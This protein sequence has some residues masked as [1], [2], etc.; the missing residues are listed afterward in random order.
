MP[1]YCAACGCEVWLHHEI[2]Y[3]WIQCLKHFHAHACI[4]GL[5]DIQ[6]NLIIIATYGPN[7][8]G[9]CVKVAAL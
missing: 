9:C 8:C 3:E 4:H 1:L 2:K 7:I 5:V 6:W